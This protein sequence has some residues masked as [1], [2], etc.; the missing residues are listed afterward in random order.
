MTP[1]EMLTLVW[2][3]A[4][5]VNVFA[6]LLNTTGF[7]LSNKPLSLFYAALNGGLAWW[8]YLNLQAL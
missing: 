5:G 8:C 4:L 6:L 7:F 2:S 3:L 1:V